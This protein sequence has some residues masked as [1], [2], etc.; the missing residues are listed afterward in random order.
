MDKKYYAHTLDGKTH[1]DWQ[2]L[3]EH[4]KN[5]AEMAMS[6]ADAYGA[7]EWGYIAGLWHDIGK[8]S[9]EFQKMLGAEEGNDAH[10]ETKPGRVDHSTAGAQHAF[11]LLKDKG[12]ILAYAIAG[13]HA[14]LPDGKSNNSSCLIK[15]LEKRIYDYSSYQNQVFNNPRLNCLP[16]SLNQKRFGFQLSFFVR[17][18]FSSLVDAD[19]L[20]T[21]AFMDSKKSLWRKGYPDLSEMDHKLTLALNKLIVS[22]S[23]TLINEHRIK[24]LKNCLDA[25]ESPQGLFSLTVPTGGGKTLSS[26][27]FAMKHALKHGLERIIYVIPYTSIIEQNAAVFRE[28]LGEDAVLEHYSNFEPKE[29]DHRSRLAAENWDAPLIVTTNVQFFES[30][31]SCRSSRCRKIHNIAKSVIILDEAQMLPVP[32][33][34]PCMEALRELSSAYRTTIV[35]CTATQPA[36]S[37]NENFKDGLDGVLEII[38]DPAKLYNLFKRIHIEILPALSDSVLSDRLKTHNQVLCIVNTRK[39]ARLVF[40]SIR[41]REGCYH[42]SALMCSAHRTKKFK[43]IRSA[44]SK[45]FP[46]RV[47]STQLIEAGVDIDFPV[48][49]RCTSG[50]DSIA[51]AAGRCNREGKLPEGGMVYVF[52]S[53]TGLPPGHFRH[54]AETAEAVIRHHDDPLSL[55]AVEE[56]FRTLYWM[57]G[58]QLDEYQILDDIAEDAIKGNFPFRVV[59]K[60][61]RI[62]KDGAE[63][64]I[65]PWNGEAE[66]IISGLRYS[67][68]PASFAR[69]AQR[70]TVQVYPKVLSSLVCSGSVERLHDQYC[71]LINTDIYR[72]DLGLCPEDPT[73]HRPESLIE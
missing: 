53:E 62:I 25:A 55:E 54:T 59:D 65:I 14:G 33:L 10:I 7:G 66:K 64:I 73:F 3:K 47:V 52:L 42:L 11:K 36:L 6:F 38:P 34:R 58:E 23:N 61:F 2:P 32:L 17:M 41:C 49:Y 35:L 57:R 22:A 39:H 44:L 4:L 13:H 40:E 26:L 1:S 9:D 30:L 63:S 28:I 48:V 68:Y 46:C 51:Q 37:T 69:K 15:R 16:F 27:A 50:I 8:Y 5:V 12:K 60:K 70:F 45:G 21:E 20:D 24:I 29:E 72:D 18:I 56:Y 19:F 71:V 43:E 67:E 31:Y